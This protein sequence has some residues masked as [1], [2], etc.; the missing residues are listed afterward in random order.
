MAHEE[1]EL[2]G[3][4]QLGA[5]TGSSLDAYLQDRAD[6]GVGKSVR[7]LTDRAR[8]AA[9]LPTPAD[10][11]TRVSFVTNIGSVM[12]YADPP[13]SDAPGTIVM[14]RTA[15]GDQTGMDGMVFVKFDDGRFMAIHPE[16]LRPGTPNAKVASSFA[17]RVATLGDLSG[18]LRW[19]AEDSELVHHATKDLWS[20][21][22][23]DRGDF[24]I[25]RLFDDTGEP[26]K[27]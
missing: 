25:S 24:V 2:Y 6:R 10:A 17:R 22:T 13:E 11:G 26:L 5:R 1:D 19:G 16:H 21:E 3:D 7:D 18:F 20:F 27:V 12:A 9:A 15:E 14:V 4:L 23:T 8:E